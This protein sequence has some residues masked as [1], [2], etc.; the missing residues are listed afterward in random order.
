MQHRLQALDWM[1]GIV[2][3]LM[4]TDHASEAFNGARPVTDAVILGNWQQPLDAVQ[5]LFRWLSHLCAP[6]FLFLAGTSLALSIERKR[7]GGASGARIDRDLLIRGLL[8]VAVEVLFINLFWF[9]GMLLLQVMYAIGM[10]MIAMIALRRLPDALLLMFAVFALA[11]GEWTR[12]GTMV[13]PAEVGS[14]TAALLIDCG[15]LP[16]PVL[17][18]GSVICVYP[19]LPWCGIMAAGWVLGRWL[20]RRQPGSGDLREGA[21]IARPL[22]LLGALLLIVFVVL[23]GNN[24]WGNLGLLRLDGSL[25]QWLHVSKYPPSLTFATL[26]LGIMFLILAALA[27]RDAARGAVSG[28][29]HPVL[30]FGQTAFFFYC[31]HIAM[32]ELA[33]HGSGYYQR[34]GL[35]LALLATGLVLIVLYPLCLAYRRLKARHP[36]SVL[37]YF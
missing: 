34:G 21:P 1:R 13:V 16:V 27:R 29:D 4:V 31:A 32:L 11:V 36:R 24:G 14:G 30:V 26:E 7:Q 3:V 37:R 8:L 19:V 9:P 6:V 25:L 10:S 17:G 22:A 12:T 5:F 35:G 2:M 23:R 15:L 18:F 20:L 33:A 28:P